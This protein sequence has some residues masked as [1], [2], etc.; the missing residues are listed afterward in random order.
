MGSKYLWLRHP[1]S[2]SK[3]QWRAFEDLRQSDL[4]TARAWGAERN[5]DAAVRLSLAEGGAQ[6]FPPLV[7]LGDAFAAG[8]GPG[9]ADDEPALGEHPYVLETRYYQRRQRSVEFKDSMGEVPA[10]SN[11]A[12]RTSF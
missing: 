10:P 6:V 1:A 7:L 4:K 3:K 9:G 11:G 5:R 12:F 2:F 8:A